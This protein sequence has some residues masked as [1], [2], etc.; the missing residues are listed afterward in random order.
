MKRIIAILFLATLPA[1]WAA[2]EPKPYPLDYCFISDEPLDEYGME[3]VFVYKGQE[4]KL[5]CKKCK[6][7]FDKNPAK[8]MAL[9]ATLAAKKSTSGSK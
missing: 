3:I 7:I 4:I 2:E 8:A 9:L 6:K 5:C 1:I